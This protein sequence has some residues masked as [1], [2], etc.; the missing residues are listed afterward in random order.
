MND[1][2]INP[3]LPA[4]LA[5]LIQTTVAAPEAAQVSPASQWNQ[6]TAEALSSQ[7]KLEALGRKD[8]LKRKD[9]LPSRS[10]LIA[11]DLVRKMTNEASLFCPLSGL[12]APSGDLPAHL[13][14]YMIA[15]HP[16]AFNCW[17]ICDQPEYVAKLSNAQ[18]AGLVLACLN[19]L[20]KINYGRGDK[21]TNA[22]MIRAKLE[23]VCNRNRLLDLLEWIQNSLSKTTI[24]YP[25]FQTNHKD[26]TLQ[27]IQEWMDWTYSIEVYAFEGSEATPIKEPKTLA[28]V[29]PDTQIKRLN[30]SLF[31][32]WTTLLL[33]QDGWL[34]DGFVAKAAKYSKTLATAAPVVERMLA[35]LMVAAEEAGSEQAIEEASDFINEVNE[36]RELAASIQ[37]KQLD[38]DWGTTDEAATADASQAREAFIAKMKAAKEASLLASQTKLTT[39]K[40]TAAPTA[41]QSFLELLAQRKAA[42]QAKANEEVQS[43]D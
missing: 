33:E 14:Y 27:T 29:S 6:T 22:Y 40:P 3:V 31:G 13:G 18:L 25:P 24:Y 1:Q 39:A 36:A 42:A 17:A 38:D 9:K 35:A 20:G 4:A 19:D 21:S 32:S 12:V 10:A 7:R 11:A 26:L 30:S 37:A 43:N 41:K 16:I 23:V 28:P 2:T 5:A 15:Y 8:E 34:S